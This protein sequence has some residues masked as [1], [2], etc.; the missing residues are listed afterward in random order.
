MLDATHQPL[1][2]SVFEP[3]YEDDYSSKDER[4]V[5]VQLDGEAAVTWW[6]RNVA[7]SGY[8]L[9]GW[10]R[11]KIYPDFIFASS[12]DAGPKRIVV[13]E[14]KGDHLGGNV[15]TTY[16]A[17]V[18]ELLAGSFNWDQTQPAGAL[19]LV[20]A[21]GTIVQCEMVLMSALPTQLPHLIL[22]SARSTA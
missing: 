17:S 2:K 18:M 6:H 4:D 22:P 8:G 9:Q 15:D 3:V 11:Q 19:D 21:D 14:T 12:Q 7:K 1:S 13:L 16:K 10:Q 5:A 20:D